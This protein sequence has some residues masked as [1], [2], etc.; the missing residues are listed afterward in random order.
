M[1]KLTPEQCIDVLEDV[2]LL[3]A[4]CRKYRDFG[5]THADPDRLRVIHAVADY[6]KVAD[7]RSPMECIRYLDK[8]WGGITDNEKVFKAQAVA[9]N[10]WH[11]MRE[12][13][14]TDKQKA[15]D[16]LRDLATR[17]ESDNVDDLFIG[18]RRNTPDIT[19][20]DGLTWKDDGHREITIKYREK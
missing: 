20:D 9:A 6:Q 15:A 7:M 3:I 2:S 8:H 13:C 12:Y 19:A 4:E 1:S 17:V 10:L 5:A 14:R 11:F 18:V 16:I